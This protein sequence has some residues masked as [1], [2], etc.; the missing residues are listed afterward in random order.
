MA[1]L[2]A[3]KLQAHIISVSAIDTGAKDLKELAD[4]DAR[5][6]LN[7]VEIIIQSFKSADRIY[8]FPLNSSDFLALLPTQKVLAYDKNR[9]NHYDTI[10]AFIKSIRGSDPDA[11]V[12]YLALC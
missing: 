4:G 12:Y 5:R 1:E 2:L 8:N 7:I 10:S 6:L 11:G 3:R 9:D